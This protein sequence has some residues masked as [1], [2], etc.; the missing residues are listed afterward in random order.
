MKP[1]RI[2]QTV[3]AIAIMSAGLYVFLRGADIRELIHELRKVNVPGLCACFALT[4]V[5][6]IL[7]TL[8]WRI[9][10]PAAGAHKR[11]LFSH[12]VIGFMMNNI[13]PARAGE[14]VRALLLWRKN[15]YSL[16]MSAGSLIVDRAIDIT[17]F[18]LLFAIP[19]V[20]LPELKG[21]P[22]IFN[23]GRIAAALFVVCISLFALCGRNPRIIHRLAAAFCVFLPR[24]FHHR[25][26]VIGTDMASMLDW[27][28]SPLKVLGCSAASLGVWLGISLTVVILADDFPSFGILHGAFVIS[29]AVV[30]AAIPLAPGFVGTL[31]ATVLQSLLILGFDHEAGRVLAVLVHAAGYIPVTA[32]GF[33]YFLKADMSFREISESQKALEEG[34]NA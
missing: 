20:T 19:A 8:R 2:I 31:H 10:L 15:G 26:E 18:L 17:A 16:A 32:I 5:T 34:K 6:M 28:R 12:T 30:G 25:I 14:A 21:Q 22:W 11:N 29:F 3:A 13:L 27:T 23:T 9:L 4:V 1:R 24:R 7:R 33:I